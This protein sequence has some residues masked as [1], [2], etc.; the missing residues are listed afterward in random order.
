MNTR[1]P[2][3]HTDPMARRSPGAMTAAPERSGD[4]RDSASSGRGGP[5]NPARH[6]IPERLLTRALERWENEGGRTR[7]P[8]PP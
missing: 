1:K 5:S 4:D 8:G 3:V 7:E 2:A 6:P